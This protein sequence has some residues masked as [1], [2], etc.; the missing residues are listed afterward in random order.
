MVT[1]LVAPKSTSRLHPFS[2]SLED[3]LPKRLPKNLENHEKS[4]KTTKTL[5]WKLGLFWKNRENK[6]TPKKNEFKMKIFIFI[7]AFLEL[8]AHR[9]NH[10][11][12]NS[13]N[14]AVKNIT[15]YF[16]EIHICHISSKYFTRK[17]SLW[18]VNK[19]SKWS[20]MVI[21]DF[22]LSKLAE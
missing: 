2:I 17:K 6:D 12:K 11:Q 18:P 16:K 8:E 7:S 22:L 3:I 19:I 10:H 9:K 21:I 14:F 20:P 4:P 1:S 15:G 5:S 13:Q